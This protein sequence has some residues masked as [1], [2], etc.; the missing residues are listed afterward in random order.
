MIY[1]SNFNVSETTLS[2]E[3]FKKVYGRLPNTIN[4]TYKNANNGYRQYIRY[5]RSTEA[6]FGENNVYKITLSGL[7]GELRA[8]YNE[9]VNPKN[10]RRDRRENAKKLKE[11]TTKIEKHVEKTFN[12]SK[13]YFGIYDFFN[14]FSY[15]LC[16]DK[17]LVTKNEKGK[18]VVN[19]K[20]KISL[21][22]IVETKSGY[23]YRDKEGKIFCVCFG[24]EFFANDKK[25]RPLFTDDEC[26]AIITHEFG[27]AMQQAVCSINENL[28]SCYISSTMQ[29]IY[30]LINPLVVIGTFGLST[31]Y[32][33]FG[34]KQVNDMKNSNPEHIG[35]AIIRDSIGARKE[36]FNR[37]KIGEWLDN[38]TNASIKEMPNKKK[39]NKFLKG[40]CKF[41]SFTIGG[42]FN[43]LYDIINGVLSIPQNI[44]VASEQGFFKKNRRFEQFA[45]IFASSYGYG[46]A[47]SSALA[48]MNNQAVA[49]KQN[50]GMLGLLNYIP[51]VNIALGVSH[52]IDT[53][54]RT[55]IAGYPDTT[56]RMAAM[57]KNLKTEL[58]TNKDLTAEEKKVIQDQIDSM[59]NTYDEYVYDWSPKGFVYA[60]WHKICFKKLSNTNSDAETNVL[61]AIEEMS[62]ENKL[63]GK[64]K[65]VSE[66]ELEKISAKI[67]S[68]VA[69][70]IFTNMTKVLKQDFGSRI[71][72]FS[73]KLNNF[74]QKL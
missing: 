18:T 54:V 60:L 61:E 17:N 53:G 32:A 40:I 27:H 38:N 14:A 41:F 35:D 10:D 34:Q 33:A 63:K 66:E 36:E 8:L 39:E 57:Y 48:K 47:L 42:I 11:I 19:N 21:E 43:V 30:Q 20:V 26:A 62:K 28:A 52:Y 24:L 74:I 9:A 37:D 7:M 6:F 65:E 13:C 12:I 71:N 4:L 55:L 67:D 1:T 64:S 45:D 59:S 72:K 25:G 23:K 68:K 70:K 51:V 22:D 5:A 46:P 44:Y 49:E 73:N 50:Y 16:W 3:D 15:P 31:V 2:T 69:F 29:Y 56:G 58:D